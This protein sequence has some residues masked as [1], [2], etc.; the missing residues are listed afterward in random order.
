MNDPDDPLI[1]AATILRAA[2]EPGWDTISDRVLDAV[3]ATPR[4]AWPLATTSHGPTRDG[5][6]FVTDHVLRSVLARTLR[7][8]HLGQPTAIHVETEGNRLRAVNLEI[9]SSSGT[10]LR[11]LAEQ[12]RL[13]AAEVIDDLFGDVGAPTPHS[14]IV[15]VTDIVP[16]N[17]AAPD[18]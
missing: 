4:P 16:G 6:I 17:A 11:E 13:T 2:P 9:T 1:R 18:L 3:R 12:V 14:I 8:R 10:S 15:T 5:S 7:V